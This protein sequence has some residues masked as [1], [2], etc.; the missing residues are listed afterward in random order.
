MTTKGIDTVLIETHNWGKSVAFWKGLGY[1][2][3]FET[4]HHSGQ[5]RHPAG[6]PSLFIAERAPEQPLRMVLG[7]RVDDAAAFV[8]PASGTVKQ[9]FTKEHWGV[10]Q[11]LIGDPDGRETSVEAPLQA[12]AGSHG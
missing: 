6:G 4:D 3:E 10:L 11:M 12:R 7:L 8:P 5:L 9:P 1:E 2:I